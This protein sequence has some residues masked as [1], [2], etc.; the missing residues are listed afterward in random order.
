MSI[1]PSLEDLKANDL[2]KAQVDAFRQDQQQQASNGA[3]FGGHGHGAYPMLQNN[4]G[5]NNV[6]YPSAPGIGT[7]G[8]SNYPSLSEFMG[9]ELS[10]DVIR[11]NMPEYLQIVAAGNQEQSVVPLPSATGI[12]APISGSS[13]VIRSL[14]NHGVRECKVKKSSGRIGIRVRALN[15]GVFICLVTD[16]SPA[17]CAGLRFGDQI[18]QIDGVDMAGMSVTTVHNILKKKGD[19][20]FITFAVRD[21]PFERSVTLIRDSSGHIGFQFR[22]GKIINIVKDSSAARNGL[23]TDH[24]L[25]EINGKN[26]IGL[27]DKEIT[28]IISEIPGNG[29]NVTIMPSFLYN[30]MIKEMDT[31]LFGKMD[32]S[33]F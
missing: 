18:L 21:R 1:Y 14:V 22:N 16:Q 19:G 27:K 5:A 4:T 20:D 2:I 12:V 24:A 33:D 8:R 23:L 7:L 10:E 28:K 13:A 25:L 17:A 29:L 32:H 3:H 31:S 15:T 9:L 30:H 26:V 11:A 6:H